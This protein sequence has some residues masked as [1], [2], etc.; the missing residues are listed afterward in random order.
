MF[1]GFG[2]GHV[3]SRLQSLHRL[4]NPPTL[5]HRSEAGRRQRSKKGKNGDDH[6][7]LDDRETALV[8]TAT[9]NVVAFVH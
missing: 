9:E 8:A 5:H 7:H 2:T 1:H 4:P 6:H 3:Q